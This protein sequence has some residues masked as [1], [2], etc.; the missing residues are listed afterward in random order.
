MDPYEFYFLILPLAILVVILIVVV[1]ILS[2]KE[3]TIKH[4]EVET[5][6]ELMQTGLVNKQNFSV[7]LQDLVHQGIIKKGSYATLG[8]LIDESLNEPEEP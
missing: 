1:L 8:K 6:N 4:K 2:R 3:G 7:M 5:I